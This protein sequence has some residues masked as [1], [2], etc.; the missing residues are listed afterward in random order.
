[1]LR[2]EQSTFV[3]AP[4]AR[5]WSLIFHAAVR[6]V[7]KEHGNA[8][9]SIFINILQAIIFVSVFFVMFAVMGIA[10][11]GIRGDF[12]MYILSGVFLFLV[13]NKTMTAVFMS[14]GPA[15]P[16]M[17]H[18]NMN[19]MIAICAAAVSTFYIQLLSIVVILL[20]YHIGWNQVEIDNL[21]GAV[22][23]FILTWL[24]GV[25]VGMMFLGLKPWAP[26]ATRMI[27]TIY[28]R[29]NM[30]ASGKMFVANGLPSMMLVLFTW[31]PLFHLIDQ[32]RGYIFIN[33]T[34]RNT[35]LDYPIWVTLAC[36]AIGLLGEYYTRNRASLSW[37]A[38]D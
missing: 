31:N 10:G 13:F 9:M 19:T 18:A 17:K 1:M 29:V 3:L 11:A 32:M 35:N 14:E 8:L 30:F 36:L 20:F 5:T 12:L 23:V 28:S 21:N 37:S 38:R 27:M 2:A 7:R 25:A 34:P 26:T 24:S 22:K 15:S 16:M 33:Y 4:I 6:E